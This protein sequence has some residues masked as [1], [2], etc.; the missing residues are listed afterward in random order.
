MKKSILLIITIT[1][2]SNLS[3]ASFPIDNNIISAN[4]DPT[5]DSWIPIIMLFWS[6][7]IIIPI[8]MYKLYKKNFKKNKDN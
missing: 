6:L 2:L 3:Y 5:T 7:V 8:L 4:H 1:I